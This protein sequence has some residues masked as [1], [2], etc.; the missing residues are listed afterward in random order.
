M[1]ILSFSLASLRRF[2]SGKVVVGG[3]GN[4][5]AEQER[6]DSGF[7]PRNPGPANR[8][9]QRRVQKEDEGSVVEIF[10]LPRKNTRVSENDRQWISRKESVYIRTAAARVWS[11]KRRVSE[12]R[13]ELRKKG[14]QARFDLPTA[15]I[16]R[17]RERDRNFSTL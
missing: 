7:S 4:C 14:V 3:G 9:A 10:E 1:Y 8:E 5:G 15:C 2:I 12:K 16:G 11:G 13:E 6:E 17:E